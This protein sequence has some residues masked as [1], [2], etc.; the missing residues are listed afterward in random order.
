MVTV[1]DHIFEY[2][3]LGHLPTHVYLCVCVYIYIY[4]F[5][6]YIRKHKFFRAK[7]VQLKYSYDFEGVKLL[8]FRCCCNL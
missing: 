2:I 4:L 6:Y 1:F 3:V 7:V 8:K 5:V